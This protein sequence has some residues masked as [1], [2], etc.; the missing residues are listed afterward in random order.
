MICTLT[1]KSLFS[2]P[3]MTCAM[4]HRRPTPGLDLPCQKIF[5]KMLANKNIHCVDENLWPNPQDRVDEN[6]VFF[7]L[8]LSLSL[9][10]SFFLSKFFLSKVF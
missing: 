2:R 3:W 7:S 10:L 8:S 4:H 9:S 1:N 5:S 6:I